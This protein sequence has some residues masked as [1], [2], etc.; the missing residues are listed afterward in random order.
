M[1][2]IR[3]MKEIYTEED[4]K[5]IDMVYDKTERN[6]RV[7]RAHT[8]Y[9]EEQIQEIAD[10]MLEYTIVNTAVSR[11]AEDL[12]SVYELRMQAKARY[13]GAKSRKDQNKYLKE[14][15]D[16]TKKEKELK[17]EHEHYFSYVRKMENQAV[18]Y[19]KIVNQALDREEELQASKKGTL[20]DNPKG[21][22]KK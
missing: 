11:L 8:K 10:V 9:S 21:P 15:L 19:D 22:I 14:Y 12:D 4:N 3:N 1:A 2:N 6:K 5:Y 20:D 13:E 7:L 17:A 18:E 16:L